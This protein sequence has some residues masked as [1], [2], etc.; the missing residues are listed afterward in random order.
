MTVVR[1]SQVPS[2]RSCSWKIQTNAWHSSC[3]E[4][5]PFNYSI[6]LFSSC[7]ENSHNLLHYRSG[8]EAENCMD[9]LM[10]QS[11]P[12]DPMFT[13]YKQWRIL[14]RQCTRETPAHIPSFTWHSIMWQWWLRSHPFHSR[15]LAYHV[16]DGMC[17]TDQAGE[18][19][20]QGK[21]CLAWLIGGCRL[22]PLHCQIDAA[23]WAVILLMKWYVSSDKPSYCALQSVEDSESAKRKMWCREQSSV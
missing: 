8:S 20:A 3:V 11:C 17:Y 7:H 21:T 13:L 12:G 9:S 4:C 22:H 5:L 1:R 2:H 16:R 19:K 15:R 18:A 10:L 14:C 6:R 23:D